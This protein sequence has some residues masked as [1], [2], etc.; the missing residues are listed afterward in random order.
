MFQAFPLNT[1]NFVVPRPCG[2]SVPRPCGRSSSS[3]AVWEEQQFPGRVWGAA[4]PRPCGGSSSSQAVW[5][6]QQ[7]TGRVGGATVP[8]PRGGSSSSKQSIPGHLF[9]SHAAWEQ[10]YF[11]TWSIISGCILTFHTARDVHCVGMSGNEAR[12]YTLSSYSLRFDSP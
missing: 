1:Y 2:G 9:S 6:E 4:V 10:G 5:G 3:Q 11:V 8:R 12:K 7:F